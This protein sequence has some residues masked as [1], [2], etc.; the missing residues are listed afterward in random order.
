MAAELTGGLVDPTLSP[1]SRPPATT[2]RAARPNSRSQ[3][4][5]SAA[6]PRRP[7]APPT[8]TSAV[9]R[10]S[11]VSDRI[12]PPPARPAARHRRHR[13]GPR[14][15]H[16]RASACTGR[17]AVD[18]GGDLRVSRGDVR[19]PRPPPAHRRD[20]AR[21]SSATAPS[22]PP[23][24][25]PA[26]GARP[27]ARRA[28]TCSTR[29]RSEPAW[30]GVIGATALA[31]TALEAETL[32]KAALL[33]GPAGAP[34]LAAP[35]RRA[36]RPRRRR[37]ESRPRPVDRRWRHEP[38]TDHTFWLISRSAGVVALVLVAVSVLIGLTLAAGLGGPPPRRRA[39]VAFHE[40]TALASLIAIALHGVALLGDGFLKPGI[41]RHRDPVRHRLPAGLRRP[42]DHRRLPR[43][44]P[45][46]LA[47]TPAARSAA[48]AGATCTA[49]RRSSTSS[50]LIH[51]LGAGT[52]AGSSWLRAFMLATAVPAVGAAR[53]APAQEEAPPGPTRREPPH[54]DRPRRRRAWPP[55]A[56]PKRCAPTATTARSRCSAPSRTRP[57]T[58]RRSRRRSSPAS[59]RTSRCARQ[60]VPR[61]RRRAADRH[62]RDERRRARPPRHRR[63]PAR[64]TSVLIATGAEPDP[65]PRPRSTRTRCERS[66]TRSASTRRSTRAQHLAIVG[67]GLIGQEVASAARATRP[68]GHADRRAPNP[69][70]ALMGPGG[71]H[72]LQ[73]AARARGRR[74]SASAA[75]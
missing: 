57:T 12:D 32:A 53:R 21:S 29:R 36:H 38:A 18:C 24:S 27:T 13:Q 35:P 6:P 43:R 33:S 28:T 50:G 70:D 39:L 5:C 40:Q 19:R 2:A 20:R 23:G 58:A 44:V 31:P 41:D 26:S 55:S 56:A 14:R 72:H 45:R 67:A 1:R 54:E 71:G 62:A 49:P 63:R 65:A 9:A 47:S 10:A 37:R 34:A 7:A 59:A 52:D 4:R 61:P 69:F 22:P 16:A 17:W 68:R 3:R 66:T 42:R 11:T 8:R 51:T 46:P 48:S 30:T 73:H 60:L 25:T 64:T 15:R 74:R 75:G